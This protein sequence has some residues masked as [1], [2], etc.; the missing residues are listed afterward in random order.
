MGP[1]LEGVG[2]GITAVSF[3]DEL[4]FGFMAC[5]DLVD[6]VREMARELDAEMA[7]LSE[8]L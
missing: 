1:V 4:S 8:C 6:D 3:V 2:L 7:A 5:P